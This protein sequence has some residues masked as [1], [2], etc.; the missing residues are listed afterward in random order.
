[1]KFL[2]VKELQHK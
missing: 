1:M 2:M